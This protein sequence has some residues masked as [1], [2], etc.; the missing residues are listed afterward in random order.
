[1]NHSITFVLFTRNEMILNS[2]LPKRVLA[3]L[4][5]CDGWSAGAG[6]GRVRVVGLMRSGETASS[7]CSRSAYGDMRIARSLLGP[8]GSRGSFSWL[9]G[10]GRREPTAR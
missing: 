1:M 6:Q 7:I 2:L 5:V 9:W 4:L 8:P 3:G 10:G